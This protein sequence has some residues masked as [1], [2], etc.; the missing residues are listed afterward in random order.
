MYYRKL[1]FLAVVRFG[2]F[3]T[4]PPS[5]AKLDRDKKTEKK[6]QLADRRGGRRGGGAK[7]Y[8]GENAWYSI[9]H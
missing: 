6:R 4:S 7:S 9:I 1:H 3:P 5:P 2:S 8:D